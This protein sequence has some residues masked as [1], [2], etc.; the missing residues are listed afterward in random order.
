MMYDEYC[1]ERNNE[2]LE[3]NYLSMTNEPETKRC[4]ALDCE[5]EAAMTL[6]GDPYCAECGRRMIEEFGDIIEEI[7]GYEVEHKVPELIGDKIETI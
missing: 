4:C 5:E 2:R 7:N 3:S 1:F 6:N